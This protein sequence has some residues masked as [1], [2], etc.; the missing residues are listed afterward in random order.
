MLDLEL[1]QSMSEVGMTDEEIAEMFNCSRSTVQR[2]RAEGHIRKRDFSQLS[3]ED[4]LGVGPCF[5]PPTSTVYHR[6][7]RS[8][9]LST[10]IALFTSVRGMKVLG[11]SL[12]H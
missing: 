7:M 5:H 9:V 10:F 2:R 3:D 4:L 8:I 6:L 1:L 11:G 12:R